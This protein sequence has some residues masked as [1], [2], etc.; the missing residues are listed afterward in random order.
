MFTFMTQ[1]A[2]GMH[3]F[4]VLFSI[5]QQTKVSMQYQAFEAHDFFKMGQF[6]SI[7]M[8]RSTW[9]IL[10]LSALLLSRSGFSL[11]GKFRSKRE[12]I[13]E[14]L[15]LLFQIVLQARIHLVH[16]MKQLEM[17]TPK[18]LNPSLRNTRNR[19]VKRRISSVS[20]F[21]DDCVFK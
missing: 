2:S 5:N 6:Y 10:L 17:G 11:A 1:F 3:V 9:F 15:A 8:M 18:Q 21:N 12:C 7:I 13:V 4:R 19:E 20:R 14:F 16:Y